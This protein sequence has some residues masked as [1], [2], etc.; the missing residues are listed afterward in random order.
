[1]EFKNMMICC[2]FAGGRYSRAAEEDSE[3]LEDSCQPICGSCE[4]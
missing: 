3:Q 2:N 1:M 4:S